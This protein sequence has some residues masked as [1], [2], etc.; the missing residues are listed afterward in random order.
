MTTQINRQS[1]CDLPV[2]ATE[3]ETKGLL[4]LLQVSD[5]KNEFARQSSC[6]LNLD[7]CTFQAASVNSTS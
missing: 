5:K 3:L 6:K 4:P 7:Y 1:A 2:T